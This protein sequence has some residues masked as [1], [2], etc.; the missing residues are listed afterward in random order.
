MAQVSTTPVIPAGRRDPGAR[1]GR[2]IIVVHLKLTSLYLDPV[3]HDGMTTLE[4]IFP[5]SPLPVSLHL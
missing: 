5:S 1:E 4:L 3:I 2:L